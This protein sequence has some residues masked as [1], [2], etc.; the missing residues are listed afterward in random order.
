MQFYLFMVIIVNDHINLV[1][2]LHANICSTSNEG[3]WNFSR[4]SKNVIC[5]CG[6]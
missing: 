6:T 1:E 5:S 4:G 2:I 3:M